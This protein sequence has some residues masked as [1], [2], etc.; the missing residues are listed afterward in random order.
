MKLHIEM[1][2]YKGFSQGALLQVWKKEQ[3]LLDVKVQYV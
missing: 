1:M 3:A 2:L